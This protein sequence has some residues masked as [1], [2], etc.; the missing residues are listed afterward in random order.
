MVRM[1]VCLSLVLVASSEVVA[2]SRSTGGAQGSGGQ[3]AGTGATSRGAT[4]NSFESNASLAEQ[5]IDTAAGGAEGVNRQFGEGLVGA[6]DSEGRF[7]GSEQTGQQTLTNQAP[8]FQQRNSSSRISSLNSK[9]KQVEARGA[10]RIGFDVPMRGPGAFGSAPLPVQL[11]RLS[12]RQIIG[13]TV[14]VDVSQGT[15]V[16]SGVVADAQKQKLLEMYLMLEPGVMRVE[17]RTV[18][19]DRN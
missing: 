19:G 17:N 1:I 12:T 9:V 4:G 11:E 6:S 3:R 10:I 8:N 7:V 5:G 15:A 2:Q 13:E 16:V 18:V 14:S